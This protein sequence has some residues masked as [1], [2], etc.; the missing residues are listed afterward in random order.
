MF[1]NL[2][3]RNEKNLKI[4]IHHGSLEKELRRKVEAHMAS[5]EL[6]CVVATGSLDLGLDWADVDLVLQVGAPKGVSR[7]LQ[8]IGRSNHRLDEPS[9]AML[10]PTNRFEYIE[11]LAAIQEIEKS[12]LD[13]IEPKDG[14]LDVLAQHI[15]GTACHGPF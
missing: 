12:N 11:C 5:G 13:G 8:R 1:K 10:V 7:L 4:G 2:W 9:R 14:S 6:D 3:E 15:L